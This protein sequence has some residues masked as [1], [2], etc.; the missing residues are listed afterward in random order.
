MKNTTSNFF[1][2][3]L[4]TIV[5]ILILVGS[6]FVASCGEKSVVVPE[7]EPA[8]TLSV[9]PLALTYNADSP[10]SNVVKVTTNSKW[11]AQSSSSALKFSPA[12]G[13]GSTIIDIT[14][15]PKG[16]SVTLTIKAGSGDGAKQ[17]NVTIT[18]EADGDGGDDGGDDDGGGSG[19]T[20]TE[21]VFSLDFGNVTTG[22]ANQ[23]NEWKT[24]TGT[25]ASTVS[26]EAYNVQL[27]GDNYGSSGKYTGASGQGYARMFDDPKT[28][29][30]T[31]R[32]ITLP[33][34]EVDY[35]LT[36]GTGFTVSDALIYLIVDGI[37]KPI[38]FTGASTYNTWKLGTA[39]FTLA[40]AASKLSIQIVPSGGELQFGLNFDDIVLTT[41]GGGQVVDFNS[42]KNL[43][44]AEL[45]SNF[46]TPSTDQFTHTHW[47]TT[48]T[49]GKHVRNYSYCY[50]TRRHNP[51]WV[52]YPM[53][54]I[55][56]EGSGRSD[57][58]W[59]PDP[60]LSESKQSKIYPSY[61][62]DPYQY[63]SANQM[64]SHYG[65]GYY[66]RGHLLM[67][68][69]RSG[70]GKEI[71]MQTFYP[72]NVAPQPGTPSNFG[73]IWGNIENALIH[74]PIDTLYIV[75]GCYYENDNLVETDADGSGSSG[76]SKICITPTHQFKMAVRKKT[77]QVGK[78]IQE[79]T[80]GELETIAFWLETFTRST[81]TAESQLGEF[82]VPISFI[83]DKMG[84]EF[85]P[86]LDDSV[87]DK[88]GTLS[89]WQ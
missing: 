64:I 53:H 83:E 20:T 85:F 88:K 13:D 28:D 78:P 52:A 49:S 25:G 82:V 32:D 12:S 74:V 37:T 17:Q 19:G 68:R 40:E 38:T 10:S 14:D 26:Y 9:N 50:D 8:V 5:S 60:A 33:A 4:G 67:S 3:G 1:V 56:Q 70:K 75:A 62:G 86:W 21:T 36:F 2:R 65:Y 48:V 54:K 42:A 18:R 84:V 24:Q 73:A 44:W 29:Y 35:T 71:N 55:Y 87:K 34:G 58:P 63:W 47:T 30:F 16:E 69:E 43:R 11:T 39:G 79:C 31:I 27:R 61:E 46:E 15:A 66:G 77:A 51:V 59:A 41:G 23:S 7:P 45:P 89:D 81:S 57:E 72:T 76:G 6:L 80:A 22:W